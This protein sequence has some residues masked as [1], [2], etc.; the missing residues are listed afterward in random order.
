V[1][2]K[3]DDF[4]KADQYWYVKIDSPGYAMQ[5]KGQQGRLPWKL[6]SSEG[7]IAGCWVSDKG[8]FCVCTRESDSG[9]EMGEGLPTDK[10][11]WGFVA[12]RGQWKVEANYKVA[13]PK[14]EAVVHGKV[15][16]WCVV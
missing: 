9:D 14:G 1:L 10:P 3:L 16:K 8:K 4:T 6:A 5:H 15:A 13:M 7:K 11:L 12:F 2:E